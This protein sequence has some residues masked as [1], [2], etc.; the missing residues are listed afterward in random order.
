MRILG[1]ERDASACNHLRVL[2]P[3]QK[4]KEYKMADC[5]TIGDAE[6]G[7]EYAMEKV[8][9]ADL[10]LFQKP[11]SKEWLTFIKKCQKAGKHIVVDYDDDPFST[12]PMNPH[13]MISG[14]KEYSYKWPDG[15][16]DWLWKDGENGF[17]IEKNIQWQD[18]F[19]ASFRKADMITASCPFLAERLKK[20]NKNVVVLPNLVDFNL[21]RKY[22][23]EKKEIRIGYQGGASHYPD[24]YFV[25]DAIKNIMK[26]HQ[27]VKF[28][29]MGDYR[30]KELFQEIPS[31]QMEFH[32]WVQFI[33]YP[34]KLPLLNLDIGICPLVDNDFNKCKT[35]IKWMDYTVVGAATI[36]SNVMPYNVDITNGKDGLLVENDQWEAALEELIN[37]KQKR[38]ALAENAFENI[39]ENHN[40]DTKAHL[41]KEA[42]ER[43]FKEEIK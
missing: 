32:S 29:F 37:D 38:L 42:F 4:L 30:F 28:I 35:S 20:Y 25:K 43:L 13:Y 17:S 39:Y 7:S 41:W 16:V 21:Y 24:I 9:E 14:I 10:L 26:K 18:M 11:W 1:I 34:Y 5:M 36:A 23:F 19:K 2:Q 31:S 6:I 40:A 22:D 33:C 8:L 27:N 15:T 3:L 12:H